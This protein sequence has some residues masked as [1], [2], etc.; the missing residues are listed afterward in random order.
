[1]DR[2]PLVVSAH[3]AEVAGELDRALTSYIAAGDDAVRRFD[4]RRAAALYHKA[5]TIARRQQ[6]AGDPRSAQEVVAIS[7][8]LADVLRYMGE[9]G[10]ASGTLDEAEMFSPSV[11]QQAGI[12]RARGRIALLQGN[13][14]AA[15]G[16]L[17]RAI[18]LALR[19][20]DVEFLCETYIDLASALV[21]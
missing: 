18:G 13:S 19:A 10:F 6:A 11:A 8:R 15:I 20:G 12:A 14:E 1:G 7:L 16:T 21:S 2:M 4:D 5:I 9:L 17:R 3:H